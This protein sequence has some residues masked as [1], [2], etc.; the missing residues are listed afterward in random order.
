MF[1]RS[2][3]TAAA[4][5]L[6]ASVPATTAESVGATPH[7][8]VGSVD[9]PRT[10]LVLT[11]AQLTAL[12]IPAGQTP[13][14]G[15]LGPGWCGVPYREF[16]L[17]NILAWGAVTLDTCGSCLE[18]CGT[19]GCQNFLA[20]DFK[21]AGGLDISHVSWPAVSGTTD[22]S[23]QNVD[24]KVVDASK[25]KDYWTG[26]VAGWKNFGNPPPSSGSPNWAKLEA[27]RGGAKMARD[28]TV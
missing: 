11:A 21:A 23:N 10:D 16:K 4:L 3:L 2:F 28:F 20:I 26:T 6:V 8:Y 15:D 9:V 13:L 25:C 18:V 24:M 19:G 14:I 5:L 1:V 27:A 22:G 17:S 7:E 12:G